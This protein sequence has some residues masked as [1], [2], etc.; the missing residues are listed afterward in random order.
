MRPAERYA[1][2]GYDVHEGISAV[3]AGRLRAEVEGFIAAQAA[4]VGVDR[5]TYLDVFCR[6]STPNPNVQRLVDRLSSAVK[7]TAEDILGA[8]LRAGRATLFRKGGAA[9]LGT[10]GHQDAGYW[11]RGPSDAYL[12]TTWLTFDSTEDERGALQVIPRSHRGEVGAP[13]DFLAANF[14]D[15]ATTWGA[16]GRTL[17][18]PAGGAVTF[19]PTL[20]HA[21]HPTP[22]EKTRTALAIRWLPADGDPPRI[23]PNRGTVGEAFG[24]YTAGEQLQSALVTLAAQPVPPGAHC[25]RWALDHGLHEALPQPAEARAAL[26]RLD[27]LLSAGPMHHGADQRG[28]VWDAVRD[29]VVLPVLQRVRPLKHPEI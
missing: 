1:R 24:M 9:H 15:P 21:S 23:P 19:H 10:H 14:V 2:D 13:V 18:T 4:E 7:A 8:A 17:R 25:A 11:G 5:A 12:A 28:R 26:R 6:W 22:P 16:S 3:E 20:W 29:V 27:L